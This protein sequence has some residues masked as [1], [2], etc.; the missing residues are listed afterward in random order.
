MNCTIPF[1]S[2]LKFEGPIKEICSISLE[3]EVTENEKEILGNFVIHGTYKEHEL[4]VNTSPFRFTV[5]FEVELTKKIVPGSLDFNIDNFTYD[6]EEDTMN[7][8]IDYAFSAEEEKEDDPLDLIDESVLE[9]SENNKEDE[10][11]E[12]REIVLPKDT[13]EEV[14]IPKEIS[15]INPYDDYISFKVHTV[16]EGESLESICLNNKTSKEEILLIN[17]ISTVSVNDKIIIPCENESC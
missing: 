14:I 13:N 10:D 1:E 8:Y 4:S 2:K 5:P 7:I 15:G 16:K 9:E 6:L 17:D 3:H 11:T 12:I